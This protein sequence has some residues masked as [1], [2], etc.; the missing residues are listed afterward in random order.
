MRS[1][2]QRRARARWHE[3]VIIG[4]LSAARRL[5]KA[6]DMV[7]APSFVMGLFDLMEIAEQEIERARAGTRGARYR[8]F[9]EAWMQLT[10]P[11]ILHSASPEVYRAHAREILER[12]KERGT[13]KG[14]TDEPTKAEM[15]MVLSNQSL[16]HPFN[17]TATRVV[18]DM[19]CDVLPEDA[20]RLGIER[21]TFKPGNDKESASDFLR[22]VRKVAL[23]VRVA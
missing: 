7:G 13:I 15:V 20:Q 5:H 22:E 11:P 3:Q 19:F 2:D 14:V 8:L 18:E 21:P 9:R 23:R 10:P 17:S 6:L 4:E 16:K 1:T 12:V